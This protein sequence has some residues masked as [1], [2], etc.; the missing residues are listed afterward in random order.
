MVGG[1]Q[2]RVVMKEDGKV[3]RPYEYF[4]GHAVME[5]WEEDDEGE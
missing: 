4:L 5:E 1:D 2:G 3:I